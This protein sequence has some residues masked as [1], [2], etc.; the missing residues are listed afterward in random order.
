[1]LRMKSEHLLDALID[2]FRVPVLTHLQCK[3]FQVYKQ[4]HEFVFY[5]NER[6]DETNL[7]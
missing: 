5:E 6:T 4:V 7:F 2:R 3:R 1:M